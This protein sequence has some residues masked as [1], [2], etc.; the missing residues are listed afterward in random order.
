MTTL[1]ITDGWMESC[2][3][4]ELLYVNT[5]NGGEVNNH[6]PCCGLVGSAVLQARC[7]LEVERLWASTDC[8]AQSLPPLALLRSEQERHQTETLSAKSDVT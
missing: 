8:G 2:C 1:Q 4:L 7:D 6:L 3:Q 5:V